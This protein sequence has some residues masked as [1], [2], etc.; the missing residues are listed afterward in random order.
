MTGVDFPPAE[1]V[2]SR[3]VISTIDVAGVAVAG[4][5]STALTSGMVA[6]VEIVSGVAVAFIEVAT[7]VTRG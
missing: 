2:G 6:T 3:A 7:R 5:E 1:V 4:V